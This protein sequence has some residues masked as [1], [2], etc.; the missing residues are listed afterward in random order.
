M[1]I[2]ITYSEVIP[3]IEP[4]N[5]EE[6]VN[7]N[8]IPF[9]RNILGSEFKNYTGDL[10]L[11]NTPL[12]IEVGTRFFSMEIAV[13]F[14]EQ[15]AFQKHF[16]IYKHKSEIF[17]ERVFKCDLGGRYIERLSKPTLGK[18]NNKGSK[19]QG[20]MWQINITR[21]L[22]SPIVTVTM[23]NTEHNHEI[24][25]ETTKFAIAYKSPKSKIQRSS[26]KISKSKIK[27]ENS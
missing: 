6:V 19:K 22:N 23:F 17:P 7:E 1:S 9:V 14:I 24:S 5:E 13:H 3:S 25:I 2:L 21:K 12:E 18:S 4:F 11:I 16:A 8:N 10:P 15:Y 20:C 26:A 27:Y